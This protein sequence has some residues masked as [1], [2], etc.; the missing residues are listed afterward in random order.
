MID[1]QQKSKH[2]LTS[3]ILERYEI[4]NDGV[5]YDT[6]EAE[7]IPQWVFKVRDIIVENQ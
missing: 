7:D 4:W 1:P 3:L 5:I 6:W 2:E